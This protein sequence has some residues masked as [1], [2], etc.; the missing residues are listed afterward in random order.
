MM[1]CDVICILLYSDVLYYFLMNYIVLHYIIKYCIRWYYI[2]LYCSVLHSIA[3][4]KI[5]FYVLHYTAWFYL[6]VCKD[7]L[8]VW[9]LY[10]W[11][12]CYSLFNVTILLLFIVCSYNYLPICTHGAIMWQTI[13]LTRFVGSHYFR[14]RTSCIS[15]N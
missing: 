9:L 7:I 12:R 3:F 10:I 2:M 8:Y 6:S 5:P 11:L 14:V 4:H 1:L 15:C 13:Y